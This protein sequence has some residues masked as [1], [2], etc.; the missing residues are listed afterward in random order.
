M[1]TAAAMATTAE[2]VSATAR[3]GSLL[4]IASAAATI[5]AT[6]HAPRSTCSV[7]WLEETKIGVKR[8]RKTIPT[9]DQT[10]CTIADAAPGADVTVCVTHDENGDSARRPP[11]PKN[12]RTAAPT[13][14][15]NAQTGLGSRTGSQGM[16]FWVPDRAYGQPV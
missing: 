13:S 15:R 14:T 12:S 9:T 6:A 1:I 5:A 10:D 3:R 16:R 11:I 7:R 2:P 4:R 8:Y